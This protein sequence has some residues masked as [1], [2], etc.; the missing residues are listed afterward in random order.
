MKPRQRRIFRDTSDAEDEDG[1]LVK[2]QTWGDRRNQLNWKTRRR[3]ARAK[4]RGRVRAF[5]NRNWNNPGIRETREK[6][7]HFPPG[8]QQMRRWAWTP[9][10]IEHFS[11]RYKAA[12]RVN[13]DLQWRL[14][15]HRDRCFMS[16]KDRFKRPWMRPLRSRPDLAK[17]ADGLREPA[18]RYGGVDRDTEWP[19]ALKM[20]KSNVGDVSYAGSDLPAGLYL[21]WMPSIS[22][23]FSTLL[24]EPEEKTDPDEAILEREWFIA[25]ALAAYD[26][27]KEGYIQLASIRRFV[28]CKDGQ[29]RVWHEMQL[30]H[31]M[32][33]EYA[34]EL[35]LPRAMLEGDDWSN[36]TATDLANVARDC[37]VPVFV[38]DRAIRYHG[39]APTGVPVSEA[40][41]DLT[42][43]SAVSAK[44]PDTAAA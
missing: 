4:T 10:T 19:T 18:Y 13:D 34:I 14:A 16:L 22:S 40:R 32:I 33:D 31:P 12:C 44:A 38:L 1:Q 42:A 39:L 29:T 15:L 20:Y 25:R 43:T 5:A 9:G 23:F 2:G 3:R 21:W 35:V 26:L 7:G 11:G 37:A 27:R 30:D 36:Y 28:P 24:I 6:I 17:L 41:L 8:R